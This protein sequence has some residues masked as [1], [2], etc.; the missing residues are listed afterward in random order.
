V[1]KGGFSVVEVVCLA[2]ILAMLGF[3]ACSIILGRSPKG[4]AVQ[5]GTVAG[6]IARTAPQMEFPAVS[7]NGV[8]VSLSA[9]PVFPGDEKG[10]A[11]Q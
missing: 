4:E 8:W 6:V 10:G 3:T 5:K 2:V 1:K 7:N 9:E 11:E